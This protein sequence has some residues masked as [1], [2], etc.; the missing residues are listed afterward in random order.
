[1]L[2]DTQ[3]ANMALQ[4]LGTG[5]AIDNITTENS[6]AARAIRPFLVP[7][8]QATLR[9]HDWPFASKQSEISLVTTDPTTEWSY[10]YEYPPDCAM[11]RRI[12]SGVYPDTQSTKVNYRIVNASTG[13]RI[14]TNRVDACGEYTR[15]DVENVSMPHDFMIAYSYRLAH[16]AAASIVG[17]D[18][19]KKLRGDLFELYNYELEQ[20]VANSF[21]ELMTPRE[22]VSEFESFRN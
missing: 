8:K 21:N 16:Y 20:A 2:T 9:D 3:I 6:A 13:R 7:A 11:F 1:M 17:A 18:N 10:E 12:L 5:K 14:H 19:I 15:S 22:E 4:H